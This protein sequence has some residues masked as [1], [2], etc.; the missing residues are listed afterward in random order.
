MYYIYIYMYG[1]NR[2]IRQKREE[3]IHAWMEYVAWI[4]N[5][6]NFSLGK[7]NNGAYVTRTE[8]IIRSLHIC[9]NV[10]VIHRTKRIAA[11]CAAGFFRTYRY[12]IC[13]DFR[14]GA[15]RVRVHSDDDVT[16][17]ASSMSRARIVSYRSPFIR[18]RKCPSRVPTV[19]D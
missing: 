4:L 1:E 19:R 12:E 5:L 7:H 17:A 15:R 14:A 13:S 3:N 18:P 10:R 11:K 2:E 9:Y 16:A 8:Y 6:T